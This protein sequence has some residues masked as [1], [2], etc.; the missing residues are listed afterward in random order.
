MSTI[1]EY[2]Q[3][4]DLHEGMV[5]GAYKS[6]NKGSFNRSDRDKHDLS[7]G[8]T[9]YDHGE[10]MGNL[11]GY[12]GFYG[13]SNCSYHATPRLAKYLRTAIN[14][15]MENLVEKAIALSE[16]DVENKRRDAEAEA[17]QIIEE[18]TKL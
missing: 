10:P 6:M 7:I 8:G 18:T 5:N 3:E 15:D 16:R 1:E 2:K 9:W 13:N 4:K 11:I 17:R 14:Q 12:S